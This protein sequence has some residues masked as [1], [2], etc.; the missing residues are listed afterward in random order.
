MQGTATSVTT[1][2]ASCAIPIQWPCWKPSWAFWTRVAGMLIATS[3]AKV[4][5]AARTAGA[6]SAET[7]PTT[8]VGSGLAINQR[9]QAAASMV[10]TAPVHT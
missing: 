7:R 4:V 2:L 6:F 1:E 8:D 9:P 5:K 3:T 10:P